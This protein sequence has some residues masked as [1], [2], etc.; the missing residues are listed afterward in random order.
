MRALPVPTGLTNASAG[1]PP[2]YGTPQAFIKAWKRPKMGW[3]F[4][5]G[6][7]PSTALQG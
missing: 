2:P 1:P 7:F 5:Q 6:S 4:F 3:L